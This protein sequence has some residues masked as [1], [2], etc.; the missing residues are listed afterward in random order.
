M[1]HEQI[2]AH[3]LTVARFLRVGDAQKKI[4]FVRNTLPLPASLAQWCNLCVRIS[5]EKVRV[6]ANMNIIIGK[7][8]IN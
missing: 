6:E 7:I 4:K 2:S 3:T 1:R 8:R 5:T